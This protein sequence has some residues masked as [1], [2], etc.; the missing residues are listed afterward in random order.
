[1][2]AHSAFRNHAGHVIDAAG[3]KAARLKLEAE[4]AAEITRRLQAL[5]DADSEGNVDE[6]AEWLELVKLLKA[7]GEAPGRIGNEP[8][9]RSVEI[10]S[11]LAR[12]VFSK[13]G[14]NSEV[15]I[16]EAELAA[17]IAI[18]VQKAIGRL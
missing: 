10:G 9:D 1:M 18:G 15:H 8:N 17:L 11:E 13:K 2:S 7:C 5:A 16:K 6:T 14:N 3:A 4:R 12:R